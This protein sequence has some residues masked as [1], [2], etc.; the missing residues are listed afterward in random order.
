V[1]LWTMDYLNMVNLIFWCYESNHVVSVGVL[2]CQLWTI[3][4]WCVGLCFEF[5]FNIV[6]AQGWNQ[7]WKFCRLGSWRYCRTSQQ[8]PCFYLYKKTLLLQVAFAKT[9]PL[10]N[11]ETRPWKLGQKKFKISP[12]VKK[13]NI[14][15]KKRKEKKEEEEEEEK[16]DCQLAM[17]ISRR[18]AE[19]RIA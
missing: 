6:H 1:D 13:K 12:I 19:A 18:L 11:I 9:R 7:C 17:V 4:I 10:Q 3:W 8:L 5:D 16:S 15:K 14:K 2:T